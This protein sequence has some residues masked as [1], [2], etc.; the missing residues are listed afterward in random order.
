VRFAKD[1]VAG[2]GSSHALLYG[3]LST[4]I[5]HTHIFFLFNSL[6]RSYLNQKPQKSLFSSRIFPFSVSPSC[7]KLTTIAFNSGGMGSSFGGSAVRYDQGRCP[8]FFVLSPVFLR[9]FCGCFFRHHE[10]LSPRDPREPHGPISPSRLSH[11]RFDCKHRNLVI[12]RTRA[13]SMSS[14]RCALF[15]APD[16]RKRMF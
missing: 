11:Y 6:A 16:C 1:F 3:A 14:P 15:F 5:D 8:K 10:L 13:R 9:V 7:I 2:T 12:I 4:F